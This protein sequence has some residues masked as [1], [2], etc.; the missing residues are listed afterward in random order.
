MKN[1]CK[2]IYNP[3]SGK[4]WWARNHKQTSLEEIREILT[5]Y[6]ISFDEFPT[7]S[8]QHALELGKQSINEGYKTVLVAG[9]DGTVGQVANGLVHSNITLGILP[10]GSYMNIAKMLAIS[11]NLEQAVQLIKIGR[12]RKIDVGSIIAMDG[13]KLSVPYYFIESVGMGLEAELHQHVLSF[14]QG[15]YKALFSI[16]GTLFYYYGY[17]VVVTMDGE[18]IKTRAT[19]VSIANGPFSGASF[20]IAPEAKLN[21][22][23]LTISLF[24]M[25][26]LELFRHFYHILPFGKAKKRK[27][28]VL[29]A[30]T[31]SIQTRKPRLIHADA[32]IF[33]T[34]PMTCRIIPNA[35]TV[36]TGF[37]TTQNSALLKRTYLDP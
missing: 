26:K 12:T 32:R 3:N 10:L 6:Q 11:S 19:L 30:K 24:F 7:N 36:I 2:L 20:A 27:I 1:T 17:P 35:L 37:S 34:T 31:V 25:T 22:H 13:K 4:K 18:T 5:R 16:F 8:T 23:R 21:D 9:G 33:G 28:K 29:Q 14:E 15:D